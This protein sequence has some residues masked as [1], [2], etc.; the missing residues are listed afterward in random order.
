MDRRPDERAGQAIHGL[1]IASSPVSFVLR[2]LLAAAV[3]VC[4]VAA[5]A[6]GLMRLGLALPGTAEAPWLGR[7]VLDHAA[8]MMG[9]FL[10]TVIGIERAV[11]VRL[12]VA[13]LAPL[14]SGLG[15]VCLL[16]G[17]TTTAEWLLV[18]AAGFFAA[19]NLV[20][21]RRQPAAHTRVLLIGALAWGLGNLLMA[22]GRPVAAALPWWFAFLVLTI[23]AERLEMTRL[24]PRPAAAQVS[25]RLVLAVLL[26]GATT[27][28]VSPMGGVIF[29]SG[30]TLLAIWLGVFDIA[31]RTVLAHGVSR[32]MALCLIG[33]YGWLG[34]AGLAWAG[35]A[36]GCPERDAALHALGLGF[37]FSMVMAHAPVILPA[38]ARIKLRFGK[39]FYL[40]LVLLHVS[41]VVRV[42]FGA[43][44]A[45][46]RTTGAALNAAAIA[47]FAITVAGSAVAWRLGG[48]DSPNVIRIPR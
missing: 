28:A 45:Q 24:T 41:M 21:M 19:V 46:L 5:V 44:D 31:R 36:L 16:L 23:A 14:A 47:L 18:A 17:L 12:R 27:S 6:G 37:V 39:H 7:A 35:T 42:G 20:L 13:I 33:G 2:V 30:L 8:L 1:V 4:L 29:G 38:V 15:G 26:A 25:F 10:G 3:A 40:P 22:A 48:G 32:Y 43:F 11:A 34:V 9:G